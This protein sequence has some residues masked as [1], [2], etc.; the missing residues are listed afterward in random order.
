MYQ[1]DL[2]YILIIK[3][4]LFYNFVLLICHTDF[5]WVF[6]RLILKLVLIDNHQYIRTSNPLN[7]V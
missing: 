5:A 2:I 3:Q 1:T 6:Y 4:L 7:F